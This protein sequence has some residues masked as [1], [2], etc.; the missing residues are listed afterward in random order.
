M[1]NRTTRTLRPKLTAGIVR[2]RI[3][4]AGER[5]W[6]YDDFGDLPF[7]AVAQALSRL[8]RS[9]VIE[10]LSKGVYYRNRQ[11]AFGKSRP[12]PAT[13]GKLATKRATVFPA[14]IAAANL[15][16]FTTQNPARTEL[17]TSGGSLPRKLVG[18][19]TIIHTRRPAAW[20][21]LSRE[22]AAILDFLRQRGRA[23]EL[24]RDDT[25][26]RTITLLS[27][28]GRFDRL[29]RVAEFEPPRVRAMIGAIGE[30]LGKNPR[31][32]KRLRQT[33]NPLSRFDFGTLSGLTFAQKWYAK[34]PRR[35]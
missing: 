19:E 15:L 28:K 33:L 6:R 10:R 23:S 1:P 27:E 16:G 12:N 21:N 29:L 7:S 2:N 31:K 25:V 24:S 8:A 30:Q 22:D 35:K 18:S 14:G 9:G 20:T 4:T 26:K 34:E 3:E 17:A 32:L 5:L 13:L 11:T